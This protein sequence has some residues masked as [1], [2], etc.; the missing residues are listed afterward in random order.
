MLFPQLGPLPLFSQGRGR[1]PDADLFWPLTPWWQVPVSMAFVTDSNRPQPPWQP[2]P[3]ACLT[4][5]GA[6]CEAPSLLLQPCLQPLHRHPPGP[7]ENRPSPAN[8]LSL[9]TPTYFK[10]RCVCSLP[11]PPLLQ[12]VGTAGK[13]EWAVK[14]PDKHTHLVSAHP[15]EEQ[16]KL[17]SQVALLVAHA[18]VNPD[19]LL[20]GRQTLR[21][22]QD[23]PPLQRYNCSLFTC[24]STQT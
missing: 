12:A 20:V 14:H 17:M 6:T 2:P 9:L 13:E 1:D 11:E 23:V 24:P 3:T 18:Q 22:A 7:N 16:G 19:L 8:V 5:S 21:P 15:Q 4:A 10:S